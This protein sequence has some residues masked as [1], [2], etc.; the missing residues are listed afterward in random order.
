MLRPNDPS[1]RTPI[2]KA[3]A[4]GG[5]RMDLSM[6]GSG[7]LG[8]INEAVTMVAG[9]I[10]SDR[11]ETALAAASNRLTHVDRLYAFEQ[12]GSDRE[13]ILYRCWAKKGSIDE[14]VTR[15]RER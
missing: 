9:A 4:P 15:Y 1:R 11:M 12:R 8:E 5:K 10:G 14:L 3:A 6:S 13:P 7:S 2:V